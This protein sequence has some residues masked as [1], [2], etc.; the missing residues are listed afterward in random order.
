[1]VGLG[2]MYCCLLVGE[3]LKYF[4]QVMGVNKF[5]K[6]IKDMC[7]GVGFYGN[8]FNYSGKRICVINL[9]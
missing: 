8:F 1:M 5:G 2:S 7:S 3:G 4:K 6:I 9:F